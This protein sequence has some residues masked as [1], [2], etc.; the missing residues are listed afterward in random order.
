VQLEVSIAGYASNWAFRGSRTFSTWAETRPWS[1]EGGLCVVRT[2]SAEVADVVIPSVRRVVHGA[3]GGEARLDVRRLEVGGESGPPTLALL[4]EFEL[5]PAIS[6]FEARDK[7]RTCLLDRSFLLVFVE[8]APV[9][10]SDW[11]AIVSLL[12]Y[13]RKSTNPVRLSAVV[14][15]GRGAVRAEPVC[16]FLNG[17][18]THHVLS[19]VSSTMDEGLHWP[20]YLH[21]RAAWEAGG[22]LSYAISVGDELTHSAAG[23]DEG[24]EAA[25]QAHANE[26]LVGH[27]GRQLLCELVG[28]GSGVARPSQARLRGLQAELLGMSLMWRPPTM[29]SLHVVPWAARALLAIP[30]L[31]RKQVWA[32]RHHL[33]CAPV[34]GEILTLCL[35]F[36]SQIQTN[37]HG[38]QDRGR[39][40]DQTIASQDRFRSGQD[41]FVI[42]PSAFPAAPDTADDVWAF[43]SLGESLKSCPSVAVPQLYWQTLRLRNAIA[44]GHYVGWP[45]VRMALR[46]LRYFDTSA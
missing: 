43:A 42:Y 32:L 39:L 17:R 21:H 24:V 37:L 13:Y 16:D 22:C 8:V 26:R 34:A 12:E 41:D 27:A 46:M 30:G 38:R 19:E 7:I 20:A 5:D 33:V 40:S 3:N 14:I 28:L 44:H 6:P 23:D 18:P 35:Q 25:L 4:R 15:D 9:D 45:H 1:H 11:E 31:P 10:L 36:E 29:N 2:E